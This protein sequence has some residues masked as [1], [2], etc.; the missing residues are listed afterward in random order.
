MFTRLIR[1]VQ[2]SRRVCS[3]S[4]GRRFSGSAAAAATSA[5]PAPYRPRRALLYMPGSNPKM[6]AK[7]AT[8]PVDSVCMDLEDAVAAN[9]KAA[10]RQNIVTALTTFPNGLQPNTEWLVRINP[11]GSGFEQ[12]DIDA[13]ITANTAANAKTPSVTGRY[14]PDGIVLPK[15]ESRD[16]VRWLADRVP[17]INPYT[18]HPMSLILLIESARAVLNLRSICEATPPGR[19]NAL[20]FGADDFAADIGAVYVRPSSSL[21]APHIP[22]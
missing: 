14:W 21:S 8:L 5:S 10:A 13:I 1:S 16:H 3:I 20:I 17:L 7:S 4:G 12:A 9:A 18:G 22:L 6:L 11:C 15:V 19:V 2:Q